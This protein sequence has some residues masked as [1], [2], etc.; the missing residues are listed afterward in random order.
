M[1]IYILPTILRCSLLHLIFY[2]LNL[3]NWKG[4][5]KRNSGVCT[6]D[7]Q[8]KPP[9][10]TLSPTLFYTC[11]KPKTFARCVQHTT[12]QI[13]TTDPS[14]LLMPAMGSL[15]LGIMLLRAVVTLCAFAAVGLI[16]SF[17]LQFFSNITLRYLLLS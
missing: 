15:L 10:L 4:L 12:P 6:T 3:K 2:R 8:C 13:C 11:W 16:R 9:L 17:I 1:Q 5:F 7:K 14:I